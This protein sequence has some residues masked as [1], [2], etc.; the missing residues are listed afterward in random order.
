M[1]CTLPPLQQYLIPQILSK[2]SDARLCIDN[3]TIHKN[4]G[5]YHFFWV[6]RLLDYSDFLILGTEYYF[7]SKY[8][9]TVS[10]AYKPNNPGI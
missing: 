7:L 10:A 3:Y 9:I 2:H 5:L 6:I 8:R 4:Y 1:K